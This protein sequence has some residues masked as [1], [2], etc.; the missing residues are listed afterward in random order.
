MV[1]L[2][3]LEAIRVLR[4]ALFEDLKS[5]SDCLV[6]SSSDIQLM[7]DLESRKAELRQ[8]LSKM[9][10][11]AATDRELLDSVFRLL[12]PETQK[13]LGTGGY[14]SIMTWRKERRVACEE[15]L[16]VYLHAG[17]DDAVMP[18]GDI[19]TLVEALTDEPK[20]TGLVNS[21]DVKQLE[22]ALD[23]LED[24]QGDYPEESVPIAVPILANQMGRLSKESDGGFL[25]IDPRFKAT[26]VVLRL[27][28]KMPNPQ[29]IA[30]CM[31]NILAKT[32]SLSGKLRLVEM[33][34]HHESIGHGLVSEDRAGTL[35][36]QVVQGLISATTQEL[37]AEWDL[38]GLSLHPIRWCHGDDK[39]H[40]TEKLRGHL[41]DA[42]FVL[43][44]LGSAVGN[45]RYSTGRTMKRLPW[46]ALFGVFGEDLKVAVSR[47]GSL[48]RF[49]E[50]S[51]E[52][53][54]TINL[55]QEYSA[56]TKTDEWNDS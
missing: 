27:F 24:Y 28:W 54:E 52:D 19:Q 47:L 40:L 20:L 4:P 50:I 12:F 36:K 6:R 3:A 55:A 53:R 1:D 2:L 43:A 35:E 45:V 41:N 48:P 38:V 21:L 7:M 5:H 51:D 16:R 26:R 34:G 29:A 46:D 42:E 10:E 49:L 15:V 11:R 56:G 39:D 13:L 9:R 18:T 32:N 22:Q 8:E 14:G 17:L 37:K 25:S 33:V 31:D 23:R 44:L 30:D